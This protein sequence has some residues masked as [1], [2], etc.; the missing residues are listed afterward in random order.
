MEKPGLLRFLL[1]VEEM[2]VIIKVLLWVTC[3]MLM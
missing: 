1:K 2:S 3:H